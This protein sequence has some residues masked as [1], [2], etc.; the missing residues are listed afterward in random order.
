VSLP[1]KGMHHMR[2]RPGVSAVGLLVWCALLGSLAA[3]GSSGPP[4]A[5]DRPG[6]SDGSSREVV[7]IEE[8]DSIPLPATPPP[9][10]A[11]VD[12]VNFAN[13]AT[14]PQQIAFEH[15]GYTINACW[16]DS[17][18]SAPDECLSDLGPEPFRTVKTDHFVT[19]YTASTK[20]LSDL[21][22]GAESPVQFFKTA[23]LVLRPSWV[24]DYAARELAELAAE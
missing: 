14:N 16:R 22:A 1:K 3:C 8:Y 13:P 12:T 17:Q 9:A 18:V 21:P 4:D 10:G 23:D 2:G 24:Q 11:L 6:G 7:P 19:V 5:V 15:Q 20:D